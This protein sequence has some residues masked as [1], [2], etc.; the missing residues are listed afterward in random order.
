MRRAGKSR[1]QIAE[2]LG[3]R[4]NSVLD[5]LLRGEPP[6]EWT[7]RPNAKDDLRARARELRAQGRTYR[8]IAQAL[9][10]SIGTCSGWLRDLPRPAPPA[11]SHEQ[12]RVAAMW[13]G[14]WDAILARRDF[15]RSQTKFAA[16]RQVGPLDRRDVLLAGAVAYWCEGSKDKIYAR[17]ERVVFMNGDPRLIRLF[18]RFLD[19]AGWSR[20]AGST[21]S[22]SMRPA[23]WTR[24][25]VTG[26]TCSASPPNDSRSR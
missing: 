8:E 15:Q 20:P 18:A 9:G 19:A 24:R 3:L 21:G 11:G 2:V 17:R 22:T 4:G 23:T 25:P 14:R 5:E 26:P 12:E 7:R 13:R 16:A 10:V 6:P 1:R